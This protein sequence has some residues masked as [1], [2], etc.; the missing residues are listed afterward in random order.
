MNKLWVKD[1]GIKEV[2]II[3]QVRY[4]FTMKPVI[5]WWS[6]CQRCLWS[7][8]GFISLPTQPGDTSSQPPLPTPCSYRLH[9]HLCVSS[10]YYGIWWA[11]SKRVLYVAV[12]Y[13]TMAVFLLTMV[14]SPKLLLRISEIS[15]CCL[16]TVHT[17]LPLWTC[18]LSRRNTVTEEIRRCVSILGV[19][20]H[21]AGIGISW[22]MVLILK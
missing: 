6:Q 15:Y 17:V 19:T 5:K 21:I 18:V 22:V 10:T 4:K 14:H 1:Q 13:I 9:V 20:F 12:S 11:L 16:H 8:L 7:L 2:L 3:C